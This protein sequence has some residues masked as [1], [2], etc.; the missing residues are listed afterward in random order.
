MKASTIGPSVLAVLGLV[1]GVS[2]DQVL[3]SNSDSLAAFKYSGT[4]RVQGVRPLGLQRG[5]NIDGTRRLGGAVPWALAGNPFEAARDGEAL[6]E[7]RLATGTYAPTEIDLSLPAQVRWVV[8]RTYNARQMNSS[9]QLFTSNGYQGKN[10]FQ[11]SQPEIRLYDSDGNPGTKQTGDLVYLVYGADRYV[12][13][14]RTAS[15][16]DTFRAVNGAAG[17]FEY[18]AGSPDVYVYYDQAATRTHFF[19]GNTSSGRADWQLWKVVDT[20]GNTAY[21]GST[22]AGTGVTTGYNTDGTLALAYDSSGRRYCYA[23]ATIDGATRL[24]QVTVEVEDGAGGWGNCGEET[25]VG[26]V[27]Y[28][29]YQTGDNCWGDNGNLKLVTITTPLSEPTQALTRRQYYRYYKGDYHATNNPG[30]PNTIKLMLGHEGVRRFDWL[31]EDLNDA[32]FNDA[33]SCG[34]AATT[35]DDD[36][37]SY[38]DVFLKYDTSYRVVSVYFD[39]ECGCSGGTNGEHKL[40]YQ[41]NPAFSG[42]SGYDTAWKSRVVIEPPSGGAWVTQYLDEV[43]QAGSLVLTDIDP[44]PATPPAPQPKKWVTYV[45]RNKDGQATEVHTPANI[46]GY[47]HNSGGNPSGA[48]T[49]STTA[50]QVYLYQRVASGDMAGFLE[51]IRQKEGSSNLTTSSTFSWWT[52]FTSRGLNIASGVNVTRPLVEKRRVFHSATTDYTASANYDEASFTYAWWE[53]STT[54][55]VLYVALKQMTTTAPAV[56]ASK[57]G[58]GAAITTKRYVRKDGTAAFTESA[59]GIVDYTAYTNGDLTLRIEDADTDPDT[60]Y[61]ASERPNSVFGIPLTTAGVHRRTVYTYDAQGRSATTLLREGSSQERTTL[62]WYTALGDQR[63]VILSLP[64]VASWHGPADYTVTNQSGA[65]DACFTVAISSSGTTAP[66]GWVQSSTEGLISDPIEGF[67]ANSTRWLARASRSIYNPTGRKL[68]EHRVFHAIPTNLSTGTTY[69]GMTT[70]YDHMGRRI[71]SKEASGTITRTTYD[72][73]GRVASRKIGTNDTGELGSD[74]TGTNNMVVTEAMVYDG[75]S[76]GGNSLMTQRTLNVED[77]TTGQRQT[78]HTYDYRGQV[79]VTINPQAPHAVAKYDNLGR[80]IATGLY[81]SSSGLTASTDPTSTATNRVDLTQT[82]FDERGQPWKSQLHKINQSTGADEDSLATL[83]W[84]D[85]DGRTIK[86]DGEELVKTRYDRLGRVIQAFTLASDNDGATTYSDVYDSSAKFASLAGDKVLEERQTAYDGLSDAVRLEGTIE[87][88][89]GDTAT[90]GPLDT[91]YEGGDGGTP[92][93]LKYTAA[94]VKGRIQ[95]TATWNDELERPRTTASFGTYSASDNVATFDLSTVSEPTTSS[96]TVI[97]ARTVFSEDGRVLE[98]I[99]PSADANGRKTRY[100][101]DAAGRPKAAIANY[102]GGSISSNVRDRDLYTRYSYTNGLRTKI[103]VD[104]DGDNTE[105]S[106]DQVTVYEYGTIKGTGAGDSKIATGHLLHKAVYPVG[107]GSTTLASRTATFAYNAQGQQLW[108]KDQAGNVIETWFDTGGR[109][110]DRSVTTLASGFDGAVRR[111]H[112]TY[113]ERGLINKITQLDD[114][115]AVVDDLRY[116]YDAWGNTTAFI[117]DVDSDLDASPSGRAAFEVAHTYAKSTSGRKTLRRTGST[118]PGDTLVTFGYSSASGRLDDAASRVTTVSVDVASVDVPVVEYEYLGAARLVGSDVLEPQARWD[119]FEGA[120]SGTPY[121][122]LDRFNRVTSSRWRGYKSTP[123]DFYDADVVYDYGSNIAGVTDNIHKNSSGN[124]SFDV[125]YSLDELSRLKQA[126]EGTL[127]WPSGVGTIGNTSRDERWLDTSGN[128]AL[129]QTSGWLRRRLD[130]NG[131]GA[132]GGTG[133]L[134]D[135]STFNQVNEL[136]TR[137]INSNSSVDYTLTYDAVGN[138]TDDGQGQTYVYD[139]FGRLVSAGPVLYRYNGLNFR[140]GWRNP[141]FEEN[142]GYEEPA[143]FYFCHDE[144]WRI[145]ATFKNEDQ[146][147]REVFV[148]HN[149]GLGGFGA[150]S[151]VDNILLRDRDNTTDWYLDPAAEERAERCYFFH[152]WRNDISAVLSQGGSMLEWIKYSAYGVPTC[153]P[154][155]DCDSDGDV[156]TTTEYQA[157]YNAGYDVRVDID[158]SGGLD[159]ADFAAYLANAPLGHGGYGILSRS[160][161]ANRRGF[162]GYEYDPNFEGDDRHLYHVRHR[163]YD[164]DVGRWTRRDP[165]GYVDGVVLYEYAGSNPVALIDPLGLASMAGSCSSCQGGTGPG[166]Q[167]PGGPRRPAPSTPRVN[168]YPW[169]PFP[170]PGFKPGS[171]ARQTLCHRWALY[172]VY[173]RPGAYRNA[174]CTAYAYEAAYECC[175]NGGSATQCTSAAFKAMGECNSWPTKKDRMDCFRACVLGAKS[176]A[177]DVVCAVCYGP[178]WWEIGLCVTWCGL[179]RLPGAPPCVANPAFVPCMKACLAAAAVERTAACS[180]CF[181]C[182]ATTFVHCHA[183]CYLLW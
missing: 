136:L 70:A 66:S 144:S 37:K 87:R 141:A 183:Q 15:N 175:V 50:G 60:A 182:R 120:V 76:D 146:Y 4:T 49:T 153:L 142:M 29:Y 113:K 128:L 100:E 105:D 176:T 172:I 82:F 17:V 45:V 154:A 121:P 98:D 23:Y 41:D 79:K 140:I 173:T 108:V 88:N 53:N 104:L 7:V 25:L 134:D 178:W 47:T 163:V 24:T 89:H 58:S 109:E 68:L 1:V 132:F 167:Q 62:R 126:K 34:Q 44:V 169:R 83:T 129:T 6:G 156:D 28:A 30:H 19:G 111:I 148:H 59:R 43:G 102:T 56:S 117:Q 107:Y 38:A 36:L 48:I 74:C 40:L 97:V 110:T 64:R 86:D 39:G 157:A 152:N 84:F 91:T 10:W 77:G 3:Q 181:S 93:P 170:A 9:D 90:T 11:I 174:G 103:W 95:I 158:L 21:V 75:G 133:E 18:E 164:A 159:V 8:G 54:T 61:P 177:C 33:T 78:S 101:Y 65:T 147:P 160:G 143:W 26:Q 52:S 35:S 42:T 14:K 118:L 122:D 115:D 67:V 32:S 92:N 27:S 22:S 46:T 20:A 145:V 135:T 149:A 119:H 5:V 2:A 165:L 116:T 114:S 16:A 166:A 180:A 57:N 130:L 71:R 125:L 162:A 138:Q 72:V 124:R 80:V 69:D 31:D 85:P 123:V 96:A 12:E 151:H 137:D 63:P 127:T 94:D 179:G 171:K 55:D 112:T 168:P 106:D 139:G 150:S 73:L 13:F 131:D 99:E 81:S 155:A 161:V 51:A